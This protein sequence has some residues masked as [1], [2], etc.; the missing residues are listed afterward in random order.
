VATT[1]LAQVSLPKDSGLPEDAVVN[2]FHFRLTGSDR[3]ASAANANTRLAA[4]YDAIDTYLS[5]ELTGTA[6]VKWYDL[7]EAQPRVP[8]TTTSFT[9]T[10]SASTAVLPSEAAVC[11]SYQALPVSGIKQAHRRGR[12]YIGPLA[13]GAGSGQPLR[14]IL[15]VMTTFA[16]AAIAL[17][18]I[19]I[20]STD[21]FQWS[22][23]SPTLH[24]Q[25]GSLE[26]A[27]FLVNEGW[28][29]NA[30]DTQ[31]RRGP[32]ATSRTTWT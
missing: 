25:T 32:A 19:V 3:V 28:I 10:P 26:D 20:G 24:A 15:G 16:A 1:A 12:I 17:H 21:G 31:R 6:T 23:Y 8:F 9:F 29:D 13:A 2:T 30:F 14:P 7:E 27:T 22:V 11:L 18:G 4:F 5:S